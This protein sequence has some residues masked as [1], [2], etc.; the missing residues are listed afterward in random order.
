MDNKLIK[1]QFFQML[2]IRKVELKISEL[3]P[4]EEMRCPVHLSVGQE[5]VAVGVCSALQKKDIA[6]SAHRSHAHYLAKGGDLKSM[7]AELYGK[8]TGCAEGK[9]GSM[10]LI[11]LEAGLIAAVPIVGS[12]IPIAVGSAWGNMMQDKSVT[13][14]VFFGEGATE[15]GVFHE[16][17]GFASLHNMPMIFVCENNLYSVY[18]SLEVRQSNKRNNIKIAEG[19]GIVSLKGEGNDVSSVYG[20][21]KESISIIKKQKGPVYVEFDTYRWL[22]H[23]GPNDDDHL[24]Y[25][26]DKEV[27]K[28]KINCPIEKTKDYLL[29]NKLADEKEI[30]TV[31]LEL[32]DEIE[33]AFEFAKTS[34][35]LDK[36]HLYTSIY[37]D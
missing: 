7:L 9:G 20:V 15:T 12:T 28:W 19:H 14:A 36:K 3:Y 26:K 37:S 2:R 13:T 31:S 29:N 8:K 18:S 35:F 21:I 34:P 27:K 1:D 6:L 4:E 33:E 25:R 16:S 22:E 11:D 24:G 23:C 32:D 10:H 17:L 5:A 30:Q